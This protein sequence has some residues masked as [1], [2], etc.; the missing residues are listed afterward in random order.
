MHCCRNCEENNYELFLVAF[1]IDEREEIVEIEDTELIKFVQ[2][3]TETTGQY[4]TRG[5][6]AYIFLCRSCIEKNIN[7][8][9][10]L[11]DE[12]EVSAKIGEDFFGQV[13]LHANTLFT[14]MCKKIK[15]ISIAK[16]DGVKTDKTRTFKKECNALFSSVFL[17]VDPVMLPL[18]KG[19]FKQ[20][21]N[22]VV[23]HLDELLVESGLLSLNNNYTMICPSSSCLKSITVFNKCPKKIE[24]PICG[25]Q[26]TAKEVLMLSKINHHLQ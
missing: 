4:S 22:K 18:L 24:C 23:G 17:S 25:S 5:G 3:V 12:N 14:E 8:V 13:D 19:L 16:M 9:I 1:D 10:T 20:K 6:V 26:L 11:G 7:T 2:E 15:S 21:K